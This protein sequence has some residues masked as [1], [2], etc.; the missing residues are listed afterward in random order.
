M[1]VRNHISYGS[2]LSVIGFIASFLVIPASAQSGGQLKDKVFGPWSLMCVETK[3]TATQC[4]LS[5]VVAKDKRGRDAVLGVSVYLDRSSREPVLEFRF[6]AAAVKRSGIGF[7]I[8]GNRGFRLPISRCDNAAC[9]AV[10]R[11]DSTMLAQM[12]SGKLGRF[13]YQLPNGAQA[14]LPVMLADF[15]RALAALQS[16]TK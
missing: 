14:T 3:S 9:Y 11:I 12:K 2:L 5:Q 7:K 15:G 6:S 4:S 16:S 1:N 10:G 13:A 8:D